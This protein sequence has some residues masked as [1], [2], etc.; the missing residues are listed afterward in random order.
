MQLNDYEKE[1]IDILR[2][3]L[4]ECTVLLKKDGTFPLAG[5]EKVALYGEG[6]RRTIK[7]GTGSGDVNSRYYVTVEQGLKNAGFEITTTDWM[8]AYDDIFEKAK[9]DFIKSIKARAKAN[10][11]PPINEGMG[12]VMS[13]PEHNLPLN[14]DG[15]L[16]I[17]VVARISGEGSDRH[18]V[19]GD[20]LLSD[21]E[22]RDILALNKKHKKF[23]L[24]LNVG[25]PVDLSSVKE[26][27]NIL[28]LSQL[29]VDTGNALA[30]II[31]GKAN[32]SGKLATT[33]AYEENAP[34]IGEFGNLMDTRYNEG[35]Y[36]GY[37]YFDTE[38]IKNDY[39]FGYGLSYTDFSIG[40]NNVSC[41]NGEVTVS[42]T[43]TNTGD[44]AGKEVVQ[45]YVSVPSGKLDQPYQ[46]L[47]AFAKTSNLAPHQ[48]QELELTFKLTDIAGYD[49]EISSYILEKGDYVLRLGNSSVN[50]NVCAVIR[51]SESVVTLKAKKCCGE[52]DFKD[53]KPANPRKVDIPDNATVI[54]IGTE[55]L[56]LGE[57]DYNFEESIDPF[58]DGLTD[59]ELAYVTMGYF[60]P[61]GGIASVIGSASS[62]V[63]GAAGE[64]TS[65]LEDRGMPV[66]VTADG[67]AGIRITR[68]CA[69]L[70]G[71]VYPVGSTLPADMVVFMPPVVTF[72]QKWLG[73]PPKGSVIKDQCTTAIPIGTALAQSFN[74]DLAYTCGDI[75]GDEME[76]FNIHLW[77][78][79]ALNI[80]RSIR[81][82]RNFEY[83]SED[84][85]VSGM[86][87]A[88]ITEGVQKHPG[89]GTTIKHY[90]ANNQETKRY[91]NNS[92]VSERALREIYLK[93][94]GICVRKS[95]PLSVMTS[96]NLLNG[97]HTSERR[98]L[99]MD[100]LR[101]EYGFKGLVMTDWVIANQHEVG[102]KYDVAHS[103]NV[104]AAGGD[105][106]MPGSK[107][108]YNE[109]LSA[110]KDGSL[111]RN[112]VKLNATRVYRLAK[113]IAEA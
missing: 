45:L 18:Y 109:L 32:P 24:V 27:K 97:T 57:V 80:H 93:G 60:N 47:A 51:L 56:S 77:L 102:A 53:Y 86:F 3:L 25:G 90:A 71:K 96:Y 106:F 50:T 73:K 26:V 16:A 67:P 14:G 113:E 75:V 105:L 40:Y 64:T 21:T 99:N 62:K 104:A 76:R 7:G 92:Q 72:L 79:P 58:I 11:T 31:L 98:D 10:H 46:A 112:Q 85:L 100:I 69:E 8:D 6:A 70:D 108:D 103:Y 9:V 35:I 82:G 110:I 95:Q 20:I 49:E 101:S 1:H 2:G 81:C 5:P 59:E 94:F 28:I 43:V 89:K 41:D 17:Y 38:G 36:V 87:A 33:W 54:E 23:M 91:T 88:A 22:V 66:I 13:S 29:G 19:K 61:K 84:P 63:A 44:I 65:I 111:D 39:P 107:S 55:G 52:P 78:A 83:Y 48:A 42:A 12:A 37:R 15:D 34:K 4:P 68:Q 30:D 74:Y